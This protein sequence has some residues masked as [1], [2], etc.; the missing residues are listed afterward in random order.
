MRC[1]ARTTVLAVAGLL[2]GLVVAVTPAAAVPVDEVYERPADGVYVVDG[3]GWG[4]GRGMSQDGALGAAGAG[5]AFTQILDAYYPGTAQSAS[6]T[7]DIRVLLGADDGV[8]TVVAA[9]AG[10]AVTDVPTGGHW[11]LPVDAAITRWRIA[12]AADATLRVQSSPDGKTWANYSPGGTLGFGGPV[13]FDSAPIQLFLPDNTRRDYR[14]RMQGVRTST[15][16]MASVNVL[17]L[18][19]YVKGVVPRE[20]PSWFPAEALKAQAVAARSYSAYK[21]ANAP[22]GAQWD[23]CDTTQ[24]QVY[25]GRR[26][27]DASGGTVVELEQPSSNAAVDATAAVVRTY[28]GGPIFAEFSSSN[29]GF[30]VAGAPTPY[31]LAKADPWDGLDPRATTHTWLSSVPVTA[32]EAAYPAL[33]RLARVRVTSRDGNGEWG[34]RVLSVVLEGTNSAGA[35]T[36]V[37]TDGQTFYNAYAWPDKSGGMRSRWWHIRPVYDATLAVRSADPTVVRPP[38]GNAASYVDIVNTGRTQWDPA[39]LHFAVAGTTGGA[40]PYTGGAAA[41]GRFVLNLTTGDGSPVQRGQTARVQIDWNVAAVKAGSYQAAYRLMHGNSQFGPAVEWKLTV[42]EPVFDAAVAGLPAVAPAG[43]APPFSPAPVT[44]DGTVAVARSGRTAVRLLFKNTGNLSWPLAGAVRLG[45]S[46]PRNRLS[47]SAGPGWVTRTRPAKVSG[48]LEDP[49]ATAVAPGQT[50]IVD[51]TIF[52]NNRP[53]G[54]TTETFEL[55]WDAHAWMPKSLVTLRVARIDTG[56]SRL[57]ELVTAPSAAVRLV[58]FP[59][60]QTTLTVRLRNVGANSWRVGGS[61]VLGLTATGGAKLRA[62]GW[63]SATRTTRLGNGAGG[64]D[65]LVYPGE[66]GEWLVPI[67]AF[68]KRAGA[69]TASLRPI[70]MAARVWYGPTTTS[71]ITIAAGVM[72]GA[73]VQAT[74][75]AVVPR[76]GNRVV[77]FDVRNTSNFPWPV[78]G[79]VRTAALL[80]GGSGGRDASWL[81]ATRPGAI[82]FNATRKGA[83][84]VRPG[85]TARL[86]FRIAGNN[87]KPAAYVEPFGV[88]WDGWRSLGLRVQLRYVVR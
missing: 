71:K 74:Q 53:A 86:S 10:L 52:G 22:A 72:A 26:Y 35:A 77:F 64:A 68:R 83:R 16:T 23:I 1:R 56:V 28:N 63:L 79:A 2:A 50:A 39:A 67:A 25:G 20:S 78:R 55:V 6:A 15:T 4:H 36:S 27:L 9:V 14:G 82:S 51:A 11:V 69:L 33:G 19:D 31:L 59:R 5:V 73:L 21:R 66:V 76:A 43:A 29:G 70:N 32:I 41:P 47:A 88:L 75:N 58:D 13:Q 18:E 3:H 49:V 46:G 12:M 60:G 54:T 81:S 37:S 85:E 40:D 44:A 17:N 65:G 48:V 87:R 45:T 84:D 57:A 8:D 61:D 62:P 38:A 34:G 7:G 80:P 42:V 24:C 30:S